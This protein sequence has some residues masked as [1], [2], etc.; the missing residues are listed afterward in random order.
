M[1]IIDYFI[2]IERNTRERENGE[3]NERTSSTQIFFDFEMKL[4]KKESAPAE[5]VNYDLMFEGDVEIFTRIDN[6]I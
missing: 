3:I 1:I 5:S 2:I 6:N 4:R